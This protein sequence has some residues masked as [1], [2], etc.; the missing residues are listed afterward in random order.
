MRVLQTELI[1]ASSKWITKLFFTC[2]GSLVQLGQSIN[3][4]YFKR[5]INI[6]TLWA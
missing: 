5:T 6:Q 4:L 2:L 3:T 1:S